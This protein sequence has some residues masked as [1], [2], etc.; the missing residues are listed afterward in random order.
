MTETT[1][2]DGITLIRN[3]TQTNTTCYDANGGEVSTHTST[4]TSQDYSSLFTLGGG[5]SDTPRYTPPQGDEQCNVPTSCD[6]SSACAPMYACAMRLF[7]SVAVSDDGDLQINTSLAVDHPNDICTQD[8]IEAAGCT[9]CVKFALA[10]AAHGGLPP[11]LVDLLSASTRCSRTLTASQATTSCATFPFWPFNNLADGVS[12]GRPRPREAATSTSQIFPTGSRRPRRAPYYSPGPSP[13]PWFS[14]GPY[15]SPYPS[16]HPWWPHPGVDCSNVPEICSGECRDYAY[17][18]DDPDTNCANAPS[19]CNT[20]CSP[21]VQCND[22]C[23]SVCGP[24][25][26][27]CNGPEDRN[28]P[29]CA[30]CAAC[31]D[32]RMPGWDCPCPVGVRWPR[33]RASPSAPTVWRA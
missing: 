32:Q 15:P 33:T 26:D 19:E 6:Q 23:S 13:Y 25:S 21:Y 3:V 5:G 29:E 24:V 22:L 2:D 11:F 4:R 20:V 10:P 8:E 16:P 30:S 18:V 31:L 28:K 14:P 27:I 1:N 7:E 17:C 12:I 9:G